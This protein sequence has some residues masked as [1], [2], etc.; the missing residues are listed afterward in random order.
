MRFT[1]SFKVILGISAVAVSAAGAVIYL[2]IL[3]NVHSSEARL[4]NETLLPIAS[5]F[6]QL[7]EYSKEL[8]IYQ[9][10]YIDKASVESLK[11]YT[12]GLPKLIELFDKEKDALNAQ[13]GEAL[14]KSLNAYV[15]AAESVNQLYQSIFTL[16]ERLMAASTLL[17]ENSDIIYYRYFDFILE[18]VEN[19]RPSKAETMQ[20]IDHT[21]MLVDNPNYYQLALQELTLNFSEER[22]AEL[23]ELLT[24]MDDRLKQLA[25]LLSG[26]SSAEYSAMKTSFELLNSQSEGYISAL[27]KSIPL[28][29][30]LI[31]AEGAL[32]D[33]FAAA[34]NNINDAMKQAM[35]GMQTNLN[36]ALR[37]TVILGCIIILLGA[38]AIVFL[39]TTVIRNIQNFNAL[40]RELTEGT[41]DLTKRIEIHSGDELE[42]LAQYFNTFIENVQNIVQSV[43][44]ASEQ[45]AAGNQQ[46]YATIEHLTEMLTDN[47][48]QLTL[49]VEDVELVNEISK[50]NSEN[51]KDNFNIIAEIIAESTEGSNPSYQNKRWNRQVLLCHLKHPIKIENNRRYNY[52]RYFI[53]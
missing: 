31:E 8:F 52:W 21:G 34:L 9:R 44:D 6:E 38:V 24:D 11:S 51:L 1:I 29:A 14:Q 27:K 33:Q 10:E 42:E 26:E 20:V 12:D 43:Y 17:L 53:F 39:K 22:A 18:D 13:G 16:Q 7:T 41:G 28:K 49:R 30:V 48:G 40:V 4:L 32:S 47:T 2:I 50:K 19:K 35:S 3:I 15:A 36:G 46:L 23:R 37:A 5:R 45:V 25:V